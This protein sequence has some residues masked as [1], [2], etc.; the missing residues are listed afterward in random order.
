MKM[1]LTLM[2]SSFFSLSA[3]AQLCSQW[4][5]P[6]KVGDLDITMIPEASGLA[7]SKIF[8]N[9]LYHN[10]DSGDGPFFYFTDLEGAKTQKIA[11]ADFTPRDVEEVALGPCQTNESC[12]F[13]ADIG[14]NKEVRPNVEIVIIKEEEFFA[15][16]VTPLNKLVATYPDRAHNAEALVLHPN[17]DLFVI[18]KEISF[19]S[20]RA[21]SASI[22]RLSKD[23]LMSKTPV[24]FE[25]VAE[26]D[27]PWINYD[28]GIFGQIITAASITD[29]GKKFILLTYENAVE[30]ALDLS[31][32]SN[33]DTRKLVD[34]VDYH[35]IP[36]RG[37]LP[38]QEAMTY[39][40]LGQDFLISSESVDGAPAVLYKLSCQD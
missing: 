21:S 35:I 18:T 25:F 30:F 20:R 33:F 40:P 6:E 39:I 22:F 24:V 17:G 5:A 4:S 13:L 2:F 32:L 11:V 1:L 27:I 28:F 26:L 31:A 16:P 8:P 29:N 7:Y 12:L 3:M 14:D 23:V 37:L 36:L 15:Q 34:G 10:N 38:Q 9:R 19:V